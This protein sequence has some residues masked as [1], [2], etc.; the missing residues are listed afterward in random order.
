ML[1]YAT[2]LPEVKAIVKSFEG[3]GILVSQA[4]VSLQTTGLAI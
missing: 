4:K 3:C 1:Y 2:K